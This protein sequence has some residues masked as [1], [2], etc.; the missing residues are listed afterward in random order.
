MRLELRGEKLRKPYPCGMPGGLR[1]R[2]VA[3]RS[4]WRTSGHRKQQGEQ[5]SPA[6]A[7]LGGQFTAVGLRDVL[8][9]GESEAETAA[10]GGARPGAIGAPEAVEDVREVRR[11]DPDAGVAHRDRHLGWGLQ[12]RGNLH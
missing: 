1:I 5:R 12:S 9:N 6:E 4:R 10:F 7:R 2:E 11:R 3:V 8:G